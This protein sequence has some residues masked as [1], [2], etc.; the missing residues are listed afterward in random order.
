MPNVR[1]KQAHKMITDTQVLSYY[2][3]GAAPVP[4]G[5]VRISSITA[6]EFLLVQSP[7]PTKANYYPILPS[8]LRHTLTAEPGAD[9]PLRAHFHSRRHAANGKRRTDQLVL[10]FGPSLPVYI[11]F[12]SV[13]LTQLINERHEALYL[14]GI[15]HL[16]KVHQKLLRDRFRFLLDTDVTCVAATPAIATVAMNLLSEFLERYQPKQNTRNTINDALVLATAIECEAALLTED[17]LLR[18]FAAELAGAPCTVESDQL[19]L[20]FP[21]RGFKP[22]A[23]ASQL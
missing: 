4:A 20:D 5:P 8:R 2:F 1:Q 22:L 9:S 11:E 23:L 7:Q 12:G 18:R 6:A 21:R 13:A 10:D 17:D 3:K 19:L 15:R 14:S 16:E